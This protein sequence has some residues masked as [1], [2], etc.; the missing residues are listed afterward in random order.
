MIFFLTSQYCCLGSIGFNARTTSTHVS[1]HHHR[2]ISRAKDKNT[3][4]IHTSRHLVDFVAGT[5][6]STYVILSV[7]DVII[8]RVHV[9]INRDYFTMIN[10]SCGLA[11]AVGV[12]K[13][14]T[15]PYVFFSLRV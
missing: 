13:E 5:A 9:T 7:A 6:A 4:R 14:W 10:T 3:R 2:Y 8:F 1:R 12:C 15:F 11:I